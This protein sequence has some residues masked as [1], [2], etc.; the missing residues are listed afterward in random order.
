M[1]HGSTPL[2]GQVFNLRPIFN[3]LPGRVTNPPQDA[4]LPHTDRGERE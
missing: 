3:R 1:K 4:I 2:V